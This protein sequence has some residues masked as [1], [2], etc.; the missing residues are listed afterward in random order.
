M[1]GLTE[2]KRFE[3]AIRWYGR[4]PNGR[5]A[6]IRAVPIA[7]VTY[8]TAL[9]AGVVGKSLALK[10][11]WQF[12]FITAVVVV[13]V[14]VFVLLTQLIMV[15]VEET[16]SKGRR[17]QQTLGTAYEFADTWMLDEL[18]TLTAVQAGRDPPV[19]A[20]ADPV[21]AL[22]G[23]VQGA[24]AALTANFGQ[25]T[26]LDERI[27]FEVTFMTTSYIDDGITIAAWANRD[28][29]KPT[30]M[31]QRRANPMIY[32]RTVTADIYRAESPEMRIVESTSDPQA[33]YAELYAGQK[34]RIKSSVVYPVLTSEYG[35]LGT[36]V[37]HC[38]QLNFFSQRDRKFWRTFCE[39]FAK[40]LALEKLL[41]DAAMIPSGT[42]EL[43]A[44]RWSQ[45]PF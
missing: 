25:A 20:P 9:L 6:A 22:S 10:H 40:R 12:A 35:L 32:E 37:L 16:E 28:G 15:A 26:R 11:F 27:D 29:R 23:L 21:T 3:K 13:A 36:L 33:Q 45:R 24:Y 7:G 8:G 34:Q 4:Q 19:L 39:V 43:G 44:A 31:Q 30:S 17:Q 2:P 42:E 41:L 1:N 38:D 14:V 18:R 5:R